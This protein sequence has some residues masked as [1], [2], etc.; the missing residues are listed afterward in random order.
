VNLA[1]YLID[2]D[3]KDWE[4]LLSEWPIPESFILWMVNRFGDLFMVYGDGS[5][6]M[7]DVGNGIFSRL[8]NSQDQ[9]VELLDV[10]D[11]ADKWLMIGFVNACVAAGIQLRRVLRVQDAPSSR[12][13]L[14]R[15]ECRTDRLIASLLF[16]RGHLRADERLARRR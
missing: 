11:N 8:A 2:Q 9:F 6:H 14:R 5:V 1:D 3:G 13:Y 15:R 10:G 7:L 16:P 4:A 12:R